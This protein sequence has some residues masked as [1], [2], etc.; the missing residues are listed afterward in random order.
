MLL[1]I[2]ESWQAMALIEK[3]Y[4]CFAVPFSLI[5]V[6]QIILTFFGGDIDGVEADGDADA[7][8]DGDTGIDFQFLSLKNLVAF[9]TIFGWTGIACLKGGT[10]TGITILISTFAGLIM[11]TIMASI[12]YFMGKLTHNGTMNINNAI[13]KTATVYLRI[14]RKRSGMGKVQVMIQGLKTMDAVTDS[15]TE[16][17]T[18]AVVEV[19]DVINGEIL[20]VKSSSN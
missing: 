5:F 17:P 1:S 14:P 11:M 15:E 9:F 12:A 6:I 7:A 4:W 2:S 13:G 19:T 10:N 8:V 18:G 16:I 3:V 20:L